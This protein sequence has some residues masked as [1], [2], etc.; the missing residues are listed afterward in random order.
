MKQA[1]VAVDRRRTLGRIDPWVYGQFLEQIGRAVYGGVYEPGSPLADPDGIR[2]DVVDACRE[3]GPTLLRWPGGNFASGYH[4]SDGVGPVGER[5]TRRDLAW[6][7]I[8]SN[9]FGTEEALDLCRRLGADMYLNLN[10]STGTIDEALSW[11]EY[12][13]ATEDL[14]EVRLRSN[15]PHPEPHGV[16]VWG[17]GNENYG[18]W[19]HGH[20][21]ADRYAELAR[22]W[23]KL[24]RWADPSVSLIAVGSPEPDWNWTVLKD[25]VRFIDYLS[26]HF[27]WHGNHDDPYHSILAGPACAEASVVSAYE[28]AQAARRAQAVRH[29]VRLAIDEWGVWSRSNFPVAAP[30]PD[31]GTLMRNGLSARSGID[32]GFEEPY[33]LKDALTHAS[34]LHV[35][36]R[37]PEKVGIATEAQ[38]VNVIAP[39]HVTPDGVLRHTVFWTLALAAAHAGPIALDLLVQT[40]TEVSAPGTETGSLAALDV[41]GTLREDGKVHLSLVNRLRDEEIEVSLEGVGGPALLV[42]L[43]GDDPFDGNTLEHPDLIVPIERTID[44][45]G[46]LVLPPHSHTTLVLG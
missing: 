22:E 21:T 5:P 6:S 17:I 23:A 8:E 41:G 42:L 28:M 29:P 30:M 12:C 31:L 32:T 20:T 7:A 18:W 45:D 44:L 10:T 2:L 1:V 35:L 27:Y 11:L 4:W 3:M 40:G 36:W 38:M 37:H 26:L 15:G 19:Q 24:L 39:L 9:R 13:N 43:H 16:R 34:W 46:P 33:D 25:A 14:P